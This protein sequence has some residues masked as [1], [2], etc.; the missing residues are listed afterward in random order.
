MSEFFYPV[1]PLVSSSGTISTTQL[2]TLIKVPF[3]EI[4]ANYAGSNFDVY[5]YKLTSTTVATVTVTWT[6]AAKS[7]LQKVVVA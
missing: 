7:I 6:S 5:T 4:D 2:N 1:K 3:D